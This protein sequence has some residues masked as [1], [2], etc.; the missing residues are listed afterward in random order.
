[1]MILFS[2]LLRPLFHF[3]WLF[4]AFLGLLAYVPFT[5]RQVL[6]INL[7]PAL[8]YLMWI[9]PVLSTVVTFALLFSIFLVENPVEDPSPEDKREMIAMMVVTV[10]LSFWRLPIHLVNDW[11][12]L[13]WS[14][15]TMIPSFWLSFYDLRSAKRGETYAAKSWI[16]IFSSILAAVITTLSLNYFYSANPDPALSTTVVV[17]SLI[18]GALFALCEQIFVRF[19]FTVEDKFTGYGMLIGCFIGFFLWQKVCS[20]IGFFGSGAV[21][22]SLAFGVCLGLALAGISAQVYIESK[23]VSPDKSSLFLL[24]WGLNPFRQNP[25]LAFLLWVLWFAL[26]YVVATQVPLMDWN[27][28]VQQLLAGLLLALAFFNI[29]FILDHH[30]IKIEINRI[31]QW[32]T[33]GLVTVV[34]AVFFVRAEDYRQLT[35]LNPLFNYAKST[36]IPTHL[37]TE[38]YQ[39]IQQ[40]SNLAESIKLQIRSISLGQKDAKLA[41]VERPHIFIFVID[42]LRRDYLT[43]Y[44]SD[45]GGTPEIE[46]FAKD[47]LVFSNAFTRFGA[48][49]LS[50]PSIWAGRVIPHQMYPKNFFEFNKLEKLADTE[51]YKLWISRDSILKEILKSP[52]GPDDLDQGVGTQDLDFCKTSN[53]IISRLEKNPKQ[54]PVLV[55]SQSQNIHVSVLSRGN[56]SYGD[57]VKNIDQ[58][59]GKFIKNLE[60]QKL[61][62][63][64]IVI[65]TADHGDSLGEEGR[66]GHA[67]TIFPEIMRI[68]LIMHIPKYLK[69]KFEVQTDR[70][71][72]SI[73]IAP[74]LEALL[75]RE[76]KPKHWSEGVSLFFPKGAAPVERLENEYFVMSSYGPVAG[77]ISENGQRIYISDGVN[78]NDYLY[79]MNDKGAT[80]LGVTP[81]EKTENE[82]LIRE[83]LLDLYNLYGL[84]L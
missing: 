69:D 5:Y 16:V 66:Y 34:F 52:A 31:L 22:W 24:A 51:N 62:E 44:N 12:S 20:A 25:K 7:I 79:E 72:F 55:Y 29:F 2:R 81:N 38:F 13:G 49:G 3:T 26:V 30:L 50:E 8:N 17:M 54:E 32:I 21:F 48:T 71:S 43:P 73:D 83:K 47:N 33:V 84:R 60:K 4:T 77:I 74:S 70:T 10:L 36:L 1:M 9:Q 61:L 14:F 40:H 58:C 57:G 41:D 23:N 28:L 15:A 56:K 42:S 78:F 19:D 6:G 45:R 82:K 18:M 53:E 68:P 63:K 76:S 64:S 27:G 37:S 35:S 67:Y 59:F 75:A 65:L 11:T 80:N 39:F 46:N